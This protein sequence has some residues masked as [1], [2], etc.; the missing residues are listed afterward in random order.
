M[1]TAESRVDRDLFYILFL[2]YGPCYGAL[3]WLCFTQYSQKVKGPT[4]LADDEAEV[5]LLLLRG[6]ASRW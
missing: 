6:A 5:G 2:N 3:I 1:I 4:R